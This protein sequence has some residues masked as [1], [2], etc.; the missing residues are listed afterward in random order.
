MV[1]AMQT[2]D[3]PSIE[4]IVE[5]ST[6][7]NVLTEEQR[8]SIRD[9]ARLVKAERGEYIW[10]SGDMVDYFG[11]VGTGFVKMVR[12]TGDANDATLEIMGPGQI[13]GM[14]GTVEGSGCPLSAI[15]VTQTYYLRIPKYVF[16]PIYRQSD[17]LKDKLIRRSAVRL[18]TANDMLAR[19]STGRVEER[20]AAILFVLADSYGHRN[21][22]TI[23]LTIPLTRQ[24]IAE[25]AGTTVETTIRTLSKWQKERLVSTKSHLIT[26]LDEAALNDILRF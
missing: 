23:Q 22:Q 24:E 3:R 19:M 26:I 11:L 13:F 20:I 17:A 18:H 7:L 4:Q 6:L 12:S 14:L 16:L 25:M 10:L 9:A 2:A 15:A 1:E 5:S 21:G 8:T